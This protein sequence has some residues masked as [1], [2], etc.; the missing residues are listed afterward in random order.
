MQFIIIFIA[1]D[2]N[3]TLKYVAKAHT[4]TP[5]AIEGQSLE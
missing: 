1:E 2:V 3:Q 5:I 4:Q